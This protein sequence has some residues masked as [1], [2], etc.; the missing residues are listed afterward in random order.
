MAGQATAYPVGASQSFL[1]LS[2]YDF[3]H[4]LA[5]V[6]AP[7]LI[8][9]GEFD[10]PNRKGESKFA[11]AAANAR[12]EIIQ[13]ARHAC[14]LENPEAYTASL[15]RFADAIVWSKTDLISDNVSLDSK[16]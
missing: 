7:V 16:I 6:Q 5:Q 8:L 4:Q 1:E 9:N 11:A 14:N 2:Q 13:G 12:V 15:R 3:C 10:R